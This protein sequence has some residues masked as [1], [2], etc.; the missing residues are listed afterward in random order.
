MVEK[1]KLL[2][3]YLV[4]SPFI[5]VEAT[6]FTEIGYVGRDVDS[7]IRDL[8]EVAINMLK[9][10]ARKDIITVAKNKAIENILNILVGKNAAS[11]TR[12]SFYN[13]IV[14]HELDD[15]EIEI[16][17]LDNPSFGANFDIPGM[18]GSAMSIL[19]IGDVISKTLGNTRSKIKKVTVKEA[20][21]ILT[22]E[23][24][25]KLIDEDKII[26][27]AL[28][29]V[30]EEGIVFIDEIDK[31]SSKGE[32][33]SRGVVSREG[34]QRDLLP[35]VEGTSVATKYGPV[36]TDHILFIASGAFHLSKPSDLLPELQGRLPIRVELNPI[37]EKHMVQILT[38]PEAS[39]IKQYKALMLTEKLEIEF[40]KDC[41]DRIAEYA[42]LFNNE[43]ENI[44]ARR[45]HTIM[46][47]LLENL[48]FSA[49]EMEN[50]K[51]IIDAA[52]VDKEISFLSKN[53][54]LA[55]FVL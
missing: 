31:I 50:K 25:N 33:T 21:D 34:V 22:N 37:T 55:K 15:K 13:K 30:E 29:L 47:K 48:S 35:L 5:K 36:K 46:E 9:T 54:D 41:I 39:L 42:I 19:S 7:I 45:L 2:E 24:S 26:K 16:Q 38:E 8:V 1:L 20:L 14:T 3:D 6:K 17:I 51:V 28:K 27:E 11:E 53:N 23:E 49:N 18:P 40:T 4:G 52:F 32:H 12:D 43:I 44:G 10:K